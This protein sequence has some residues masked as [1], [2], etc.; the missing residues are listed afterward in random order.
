MS[1]QNQVLEMRARLAAHLELI[2]GREAA[3]D[4]ERKADTKEQ[5][6]KLSQ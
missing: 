5:A 6:T 1:N 4:E 2:D 3:T